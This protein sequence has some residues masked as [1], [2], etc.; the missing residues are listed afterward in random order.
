MVSRGRRTC[1]HLK[2]PHFQIKPFLEACIYGEYF[3]AEFER[4]RT[5]P[6]Q[7]RKQFDENSIK[8]LANSIKEKGLLQPIVVRKVEDK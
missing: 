3:H 4:H 1:H 8:E 5:R 6:N 7:P 2:E